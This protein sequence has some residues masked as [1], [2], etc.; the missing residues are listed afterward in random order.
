MSENEELIRAV[1]RL[2]KVVEKMSRDRRADLSMV[3]MSITDL[4]VLNFKLFLAILPLASTLFVIY[5]V[6]TRVANL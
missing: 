5:Y 4:A 1:K 3:S 6:V 2:E